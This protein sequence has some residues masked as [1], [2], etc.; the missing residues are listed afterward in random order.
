[1][2]MGEHEVAGTCSL[3][4]SVQHITMR[5]NDIIMPLNYELESIGFWSFALVTKSFKTLRLYSLSQNKR[6]I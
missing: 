6:A 2:V 1:M 4:I 5:L 3:F